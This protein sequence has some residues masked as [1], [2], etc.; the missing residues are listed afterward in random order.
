MLILVTE[1]IQYCSV[2][3]IALIITFQPIA[4]WCGA[5]GDYGGIHMLHKSILLLY[6]GGTGTH[7][8]IALTASLMGAELVM[9]PPTAM[10]TYKAMTLSTG[11]P[12]ATSA[13]DTVVE[14]DVKGVKRGE[15]SVPRSMLDQTGMTRFANIPHLFRCCCCFHVY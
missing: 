11:V 14:G 13:A 4:A 15:K 1:L 2:F 8:P 12:H 10:A 5:T 7:Y 6:T 9:P 3:F